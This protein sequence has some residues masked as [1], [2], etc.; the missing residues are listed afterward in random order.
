MTVRKLM[1]PAEMASTGGRTGMGGYGEAQGSGLGL[2]WKSQRSGRKAGG[3]GRECSES[4]HKL[5]E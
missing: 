4:C 5:L 3:G 1:P 2:R